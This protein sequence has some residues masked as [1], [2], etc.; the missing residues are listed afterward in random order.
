MRCPIRHRRRLRQPPRSMKKRFPSSSTPSLQEPNSKKIS[1]RPSSC[2]GL[3]TQCQCHSS[4]KTLDGFTKIP[5]PIASPFSWASPDYSQSAP[6][7]RRC[8]S[9]PVSSPGISNKGGDTSGVLTNHPLSPEDAKIVAAS[10]S[11]PSPAKA[12]SSASVNL[13][14]VQA[15][16]RRSFSD[17][18]PK[19]SQAAMTQPEL[20]V[21][22]SDFE[23]DRMKDG[24]REMRQWL[25]EV[26]REGEE[27]EVEE[28]GGSELLDD[29]NG[30]PKDHEP[31]T[32][33]E[34]AVSVETSGKV[35]I[36]HIKCPC[37]KGFRIL[38]YGNN[39]YYKLL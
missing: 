18:S 3:N 14:V 36:I 17:P 15:I 34:E 16:L 9:D 1:L 21:G 28:D 22:S 38:L 32:E 27:E 24:M 11:T 12:G 20:K 30:A 25:D 23:F 5:L 4:C 19:A 10:A 13:P 2:Y 37:G 7:L 35:L 31:K 6:T 8:V 33:S 26:M 29:I 39:C